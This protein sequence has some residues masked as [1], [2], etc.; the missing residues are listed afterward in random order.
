MK[1]R[2]TKIKPLAINLFFNRSVLYEFLKV[3][4]VYQY[5]NFFLIFI[6][7]YLHTHFF[8]IKENNIN[9]S[10]NFVKKNIIIIKERKQRRKTEIYKQ[11]YLVQSAFSWNHHI[12]RP[13]VHELLI[14]GLIIML[15]KQ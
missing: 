3:H 4:E 5:L 11:V 2:E 14:L 7:T 13:N 15:I 1:A 8:A 12:L 6:F 10:V 9:S